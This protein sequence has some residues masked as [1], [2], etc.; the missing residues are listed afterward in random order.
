VRACVCVCVCVC[1][2]VCVCVRACVRACALAYVLLIVYANLSVE[3]NQALSIQ[4]A[5]WHHK[6]FTDPGIHEESK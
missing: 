4:D 3:F 5:L 1:G 6:A 2:C